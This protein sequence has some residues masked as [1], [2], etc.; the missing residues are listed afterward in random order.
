LP[1]VA[2]VEPQVARQQQKRTTT[3]NDPFFSQQWHLYNTGQ[4]GGESGIDINSRDVWD[5][6]HGSGV[7]IGIVDDGLEKSHPDIA[8]NYNPT[9]SFDFNFND[10][11]PEPPSFSGADS[12]T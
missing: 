8:P 4:G 5:S 1:G 10:T 2:A 11:N 9:L 12:R 7:V 6:Y 3:P